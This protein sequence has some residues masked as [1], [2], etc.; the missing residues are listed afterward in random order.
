MAIWR[1]DA[2]AEKN[3][4]FFS[5]D[6]LCEDTR[7]EEGCGRGGILPTNAQL[8]WLVIRLVETPMRGWTALTGLL[9]EAT[10]LC[11]RCHTL[12]GAWKRVRISQASRESLCWEREG[13]KMRRP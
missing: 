9:L 13:S 7:V 5:Q 1:C 8:S 3:D 10:P 11:R 12:P 6:A 2:A 4:L